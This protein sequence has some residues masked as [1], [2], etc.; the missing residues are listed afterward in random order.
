MWIMWQK[1][2]KFDPLKK[3][4]HLNAFFNIDVTKKLKWSNQKWL[5]YGLL[6]EKIIQ[7]YSIIC[8]GL[9]FF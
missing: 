2:D 6:D 3:T 5:N 4:T 8:F 1:L 7:K 9:K